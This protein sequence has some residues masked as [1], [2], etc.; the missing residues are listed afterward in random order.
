M[1]YT[2]VEEIT[3]IQM[4]PITKPSEQVRLT[5]LRNLKSFI[6]EHALI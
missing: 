2:I 1:E 6:G 5:N 3:M 4:Y